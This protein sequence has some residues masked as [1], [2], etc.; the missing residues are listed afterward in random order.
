VG[1][2]V[3]RSP[4]RYGPPMDADRYDDE[5]VRLYE[6]LLNAWNRQDGDAMA[7]TFADDGEMIGF[8]GS[9][10]GGR[11]EIASEMSRIFA[12]HETATFVWKVRSA[13]P[14]A[15]GLG[16]LRAVAG[17]VPPGQSDINP[18][19]NTHHTVLASRSDDGWRIV[20]FQNTPAQFHGRPELKERLTEELRRLL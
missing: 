14:L 18:D 13:R 20:L 6:T 1:E 19:V 15:P 2:V 4:A 10:V 16:L 17:M 9:Q 11:S 12:D 5:V 7:A 8:D 3:I